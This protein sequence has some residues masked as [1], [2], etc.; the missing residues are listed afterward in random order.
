MDPEETPV[1]P[2]KKRGR[3]A[4]PKAKKSRK[5]H[6]DTRKNGTLP[7]TK[8]GKDSFTRQQRTYTETLL[9]D[10]MGNGTRAAE[11][12]GY[13]HPQMASKRLQRLPHIQEE[14]ATRANEH[15]MTANEVLA[16]LKKIGETEWGELLDIK[17]N[18]RGEVVK[19]TVL[20]RDVVKALELNGRYH[21]LFDSGLLTFKAFKDMMLTAATALM[22]AID[23]IGLDDRTSQ[24]LLDAVERRWSG[25]R[26]A[27]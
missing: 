11:V 7:S 5:R 4:K 10:P 23:E 2:P 22:E 24:D 14:L 13:S 1:A 3:P 8:T 17:C 16:R 15:A 19:S 26:V 18:R 21:G 6:P 27:R 12:A 20:L 9:S 25:I